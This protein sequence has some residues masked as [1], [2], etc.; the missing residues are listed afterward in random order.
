MP[1]FR[2][3]SGHGESIDRERLTG[4]VVLCFYETESTTSLNAGLKDELRRYEAGLR[5]GERPF[6]LAVADCSKARWPLIP[7]WERALDQRSRKIGYTLYGDWDG[8]MRK[9]FRFAE[10]DANF[11]LIDAS[12]KIRYR[13]SGKINENQIGEILKLLCEISEERP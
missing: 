11:L 3:V 1:D 6:V 13:A 12:G 7:L 10:S 4:K 8:A 5:A 2:I 9:D